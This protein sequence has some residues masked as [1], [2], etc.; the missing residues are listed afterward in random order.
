VDSNIFIYVLDRHPRFGELPRDY[1]RESRRERRALTSTFVIAEVCA[2]LA[3]RGR[4]DEIKGFADAL[5][6]YG[7]LPK[8]PVCLR[9]FGS[10]GTDANLQGRLGGFGQ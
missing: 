6:G 8:K 3:K 9:I 7:S 2:Y 4:A 10:G 1:S 5:R